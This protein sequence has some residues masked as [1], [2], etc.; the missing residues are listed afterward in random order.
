[1]RVIETIDILE[2]HNVALR[3]LEK[4]YDLVE[5]LVK[6]GDGVVIQGDSRRSRRELLD[7]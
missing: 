6:V 5:V 4:I 1:M 3:H 7:A 2:N